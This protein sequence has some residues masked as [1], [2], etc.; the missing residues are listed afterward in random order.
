M[1]PV[2]DEQL[3]RTEI[4]SQILM[5]GELFIPEQ[6]AGAK[7]G[8]QEIL[9]TCGINLISSD[10]TI[11]DHSYMGNS[12]VTIVKYSL[13]YELK[14]G[15]AG[16]RVCLDGIVTLESDG[17]GTRNIWISPRPYPSRPSFDSPHTQM[18][19]ISDDG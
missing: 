19:A 9:A 12:V 14:R 16:K 4:F 17:Q 2:K 3:D 11:L 7:K 8:I 10:Y 1:I 18:S 5:V 13:D 6:H 15:K